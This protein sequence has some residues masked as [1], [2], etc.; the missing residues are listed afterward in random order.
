MCSNSFFKK[1]F[2]TC[3]HCGHDTL[4]GHIIRGRANYNR[5]Y[6]FIMCRFCG[7]HYNLKESNLKESDHEQQKK[8]ERKEVMVKERS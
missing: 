5:V 8:N 3:P 1:Q 4:R 2:G 7:K 6:K